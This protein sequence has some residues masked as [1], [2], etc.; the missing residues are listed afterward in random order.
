MIYD[1]LSAQQRAA[2]IIWLMAEGGRYTTAEAAEILGM[3]YM[4]AY[5]LLHDI[6]TAVPSLIEPTENGGKWYIP[7]PNPE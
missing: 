5:W 7:P 2:K 4:G 3:S 1:D 6:K